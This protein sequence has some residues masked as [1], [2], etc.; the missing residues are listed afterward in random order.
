MASNRTSLQFIG[1]ASCLVHFDVE[2]A[3]RATRD[4]PG[5]PG[6][7][8]ILSISINEEW[9]DASHFSDKTLEALRQ[10]ISEEIAGE[11]DD[12]EE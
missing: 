5:H 4:H 12:E 10:S 8:I 1:E 7:I 6:A 11:E 9:V 2:K 3:E